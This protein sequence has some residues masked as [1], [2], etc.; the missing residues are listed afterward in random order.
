MPAFARTSANWRSIMARKITSRFHLRGTLL[1]RTPL[2]VGGY[3][4]DVDTDLPLARN[5]AGQLYVPGTSLSGALR[6]WCEEAFD[7]PHLEYGDGRQVT[8]QVWGYQNR[9]EST[10]GSASHVVVED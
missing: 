9:C 8:E 4:E 1:A 7:D 3:G 5:G 2:H 10:G 6:Q